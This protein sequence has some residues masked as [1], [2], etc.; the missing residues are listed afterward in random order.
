MPN[1]SEPIRCFEGNTQPHQPFWTFRN[2]VEGQEPELELYGYI[3]EYSWFDDDITP[4][5]FKDDLN[6][7]GQG[8]PVTIRMNSYGG[9]VIAASLMHNIIEEYPGRV[10]V[11]VDGIAASAATVVAVAGDVI[12][13]QETAYFMIHDPAVVF[14]LAQLNIEDLSRMTD[15]LKA[16]K[17]G[18]VNAY[19]TKTGLSRA[20]LS[21]LMT[22]ET[23]MDAQK[24]VYLGF[25]DEI[26]TGTPKQIELPENA[27]VVNALRS[28]VNLPEP[29]KAL[30]SQ[31]ADP[32]VQPDSNVGVQP[33]DGGKN[34]RS[35]TNKVADLLRAEA[36]LYKKE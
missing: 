6:K 28:F 8:G 30:L 35:G 9:D 19:V 15:S 13:M 31:R 22:E 25:A 29:L 12:R 24:A 3:S 23:W 4:K 18:I 32:V 17:D 1:K 26:I 27:A 11:Q 2:A 36:K 16:V 21:K 5:M 34:N 7:F 14:F 10:T 20:R 33:V